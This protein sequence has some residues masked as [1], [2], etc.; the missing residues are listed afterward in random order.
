[1]TSGARP[2]GSS[3][4][5]RKF[6]G[7]R[8]VVVGEMRSGSN[9]AIAGI[10]ALLCAALLAGCGA[11]RPAGHP[12]RAHAR[13][14]AHV[15]PAPAPA[16]AAPL[17]SAAS[18]HRLCYASPKACGFPDP[19]ASYP[20]AAYVGPH[21]A[22]RSV[23]CGSLTPRSGVV[24]LATRGATLRGV[25]LRGRI[26]VSA[27][28]VTIKDVCVKWNGSGS[29]DTPPAIEVAAPGARIL[30][31]RIAGA[32]ATD[33][34]TQATISDVTADASARADHV[35]MSNCSECVHGDGW[36]LTD[37]YVDADGLPCAG[38]YSGTTCEGGYDHSEDVY[39]DTGSLTV[40]HDVLINP[41][42]QTATV[43]CNTDNGGNQQPCANQ[44]T[45]RDSLLAGGG[46]TIYGCSNANAPG[47]SHV[48]IVGNRF[49]RC[50]G[51]PVY[52]PSTGGSTCGQAD[53]ASGSA[54]GLY[55]YDGYYGWMLNTYCPKQAPGHATW[56]GNVW[57][58]TGAAV[59]CRQQFQ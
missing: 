18:R 42:A 32:N 51:K 4:R 38:G 53:Q 15:G 44:V 34:S 24:T 21:S 36:T 19:A 12:A 2:R 9:R 29:V 5:P 59:P 7:T 33:K 41:E 22:T 49:A 37:S 58:D 17:V 57:D 11:A 13:L 23:A 16:A 3:P 20:N 40:K 28:D 39:C 14:A 8:F 54:N 48:D 26:V 35:E 45:I 31:A 50:T 47:T 6:A 55:P 56:T 25:D 27:A 1:M 52:H 30:D 10:V 43:F 46:E